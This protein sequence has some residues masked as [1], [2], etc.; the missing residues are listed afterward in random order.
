M[1]YTTVIYVWPGERSVEMGEL[2][3]AWGSGPVIWND[4]AMRYVG[5]SRHGYMSCID[6]VW[7]LA[8]QSNIPFHHRAV[9]AMI[10]D[11][12]YVLREH[13]Q[14]AAECIRLYLADFPVDETLVNHWPA[15]AELFEI[16]PDCPAIGLWL[17]SVCE[18]PFNGEWDEDNEEYKRPDWSRYWSLFDYLLEPAEEGDHATN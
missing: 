5:V 11:R 15:L 14:K 10:Y 6:K 18:N 4:M 8:N 9:L 1:S 3:N 16:N 17:T 2:R 12:M 13:Y 7:P